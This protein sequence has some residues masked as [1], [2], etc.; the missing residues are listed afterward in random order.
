M[1]LISSLKSLE[2]LCQG[3]LLAVY[4]TKGSHSKANNKKPPRLQKGKVTTATTKI[5]CKLGVFVADLRGHPTK[6][7][8]IKKIYIYILGKF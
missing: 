4:K 5:L 7:I 8:K 6:K 3:N 2:K 1:M